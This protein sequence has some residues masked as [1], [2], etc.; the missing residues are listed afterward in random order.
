M[1]K[2]SDRIKFLNRFRG[3]NPFEDTDVAGMYKKLRWGNNP[4][5]AWTIDAPEDMATIGELARL[6]FDDG[7]R[8]E[9][10]EYEAPYLAVGLDTNRLYVVPKDAEGNPVDVPDA[11]YVD[12]GS[13]KRTDYYSDKGGTPALYYH[14]HE[15]PLPSVFE[16]PDTGCRII[17]PR[18]WRGGPSYVVSEEGII[19]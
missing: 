14:K 7:T 18:R 4:D 11:G 8:E 9:Y 19:G 1:P 6:D 15:R 13:L 12:I 5:E 16:N 10:D 17:A 2:R 3:G